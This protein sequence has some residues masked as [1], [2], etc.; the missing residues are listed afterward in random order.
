LKRFIVLFSFILLLV[1][2]QKTF[3]A[4]ADVLSG[5][6]PY[7]GDPNTPQVATT[8]PLHFAAYSNRVAFFTLQETSDIN[9]LV[10]RTDKNA[11]KFEFWDSNKVLI[12]SY[13][14]STTSPTVDVTVSISIKGVKYVVARAASGGHSSDV[15]KL[16]A[17]ADAP[18]YHE[19]VK[20]FYL[21]TTYNAASLQWQPPATNPDYTGS[22][23][24][25]N[26]VLLTT[27]SKINTSYIDE[28]VS[29]KT[30]YT[31]KITSLYSDGFETAGIQKNS[32]TAEAPVPEPPQ[33]PP[34]NVTEVK[35][36]PY[37]NKI[38]L[39]WV[40]PTD[41]NFK[42]VKI[43]RDT[44]QPT[45]FLQKIFTGSTAHAASTPIF[46]TNGTYF[47]D[48][49]VQPKTEYEYTLTTISDQGLE[50]N[51]VTVQTTTTAEPTPQIENGIFKEQGNGDYLISWDKPT[52]GTVKILVGNETYKT[53]SASAK[54]YT[55]PKADLKYNKLGD[56]VI[57]M[58]P[59]GTFGTEGAAITY[60]GSKITMPFNVDDLL[61]S[62]MAL[63]LLVSPFILFTLA[64]LLVPKFRK[65]IYAT[66]EKYRSNGSSEKREILGERRF[67]TEE[68]EKHEGKEYL[69]KRERI[70]REQRQKKEVK[71]KSDK[72]PRERTMKPRERIG[73][74]SKLIRVEKELRTT[75]EPRENTRQPRKPR[76]RREAR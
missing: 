12:N 14:Q 69:K 22:K 72:E 2:L 46:E 39:S 64:F 8:M 44:V 15:T 65:L 48:L 59:I 33:K 71:I 74:N 60:T 53:V 34:G 76:G 4:E 7:Y 56:P 75:R 19:E 57:S 66:L 62:G 41:N 21:T 37:Y 29:E 49:S 11:V 51:G 3:A 20:A 63:L 24:Y 18:I 38:K 13:T 45:S 31:Y 70:E 40:L 17:W 9:R 61:S 50:S 32:T 30:A 28:T 10:F 73:K 26:G 47:N 67:Q 58:Q 1:P 52:E 55:I 5:I 6:T 43:Y 25:R 27:V 36:N 16:E 23:I 42:N 54:T 68:K 35:V